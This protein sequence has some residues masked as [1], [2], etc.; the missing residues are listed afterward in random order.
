MSRLAGH[1]ALVTGGGTGIGA[2][3]AR[4]LAADGAAVSLVGRRR[5][6]L[7]AMAAELSGTFAATADVGDMA[8]VEAAFAAASARHGPVSILVNNAGLAASNQFSC[9]SPEEWRAI[10]A[11][12]LDGVFN[13]SSVAIAA[14]L[15]AGYGRNVT[16]ASTA[17]LQG[18]AYTAPYVAA[19]HGAVGLMRALAA[20]Y[21]GKDV[22]ANAICPGFTDTEIVAEAARTIRAKTG[23]S[24]CEA[25]A[26]LAAMNPSGR[27]IDPREVATSVVELALS[28]RTGEAVEIA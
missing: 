6:P 5:A 28:E 4:A 1:H 12:N 16:V 18:F 22:T 26:E 8:Q 13:C 21:A 27:L 15:A 25:R 9:V 10:M 19:K 20:E 2:A 3:I 7:D 14:M 17:G 23:R 24:E 11:T